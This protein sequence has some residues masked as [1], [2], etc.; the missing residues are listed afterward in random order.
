MGRDDKLHLIIEIFVR[1]IFLLMSFICRKTLYLHIFVHDW[2]QFVCC[3]V[4]YYELVF[5]L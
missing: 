5:F 2:Q 3:F 1:K 4:R